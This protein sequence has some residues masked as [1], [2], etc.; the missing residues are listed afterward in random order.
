VDGGFLDIADLG[1][2]LK[3]VKLG[4][5]ALGPRS[6]RILVEMVATH[7]PGLIIEFGSGASTVALA[8][9]IH[10]L[11]SGAGGARVVSLEQDEDHA[12]RTRDLLA[13]AGLQ[14]EA[15][16]IVAPLTEQTIEGVRTTCYA[17]PRDFARVLDGRTAGLVVIDGPA[18]APGARFGTLPLVRP[19]VAEGASF[20]L[21]DAL[22][23]GELGI[24]RRWR[25]LS[26]IRV[27]GI[28]LIEK[29][30]LTGTVRC[31]PQ[32]DS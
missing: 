19:Y 4:T 26:Y 12:Q 22:R 2:Q 5:W 25:P 16:V 8:W 11:Q 32:A 27:D 15:V 23:D 31:E 30:L 21:D 10:S 9:A 14:D 17:M 1:E 20:V 28:R 13:R 6:L 18:A 3:G 24:A 29:G 7:R